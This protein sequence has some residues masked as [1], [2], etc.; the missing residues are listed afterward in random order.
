MP[1]ITDVY[2]RE[3]LAPTLLDLLNVEQPEDMTG[4]SLIKH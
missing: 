2:A 4:E 1:I 3:V